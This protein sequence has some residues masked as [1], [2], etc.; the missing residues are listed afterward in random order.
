MS[1][2]LYKFF[3][4]AVALSMV[5]ALP[6]MALPLPTATVERHEAP[7][8]VA[9]ETQPTAPAV[10][11]DEVPDQVE[12][13]QEL[14]DRTGPAKIVIELVDQ[15]AVAIY[16]EAQAAKQSDVAALAATR[17]QLAKIDAAQEALQPV[18]DK[19][20]ATV[21]YRT[22][23]V[24]NGIYAIVEAEK[25]DELAKQPGVKA[26]H[27][28]ITKSLDNWHSVPLIGAPQLWDAGGLFGGLDGSGMKI[29]VID[30]GI[31]YMH[32]NFGGP[33]TQGAY[34]AN[35]T[36]VITDTY[37]GNLLYP[38]MKVVGGWDFA[39]DDYDANPN[40]PTYNPI[41]SPDPDPADCGDHG[42]H[43]AG[44]AAGYGVNANGTTYA[45]PYNSSLNFGQFKIGPGVAPKASLYSLRVFGCEGSTD[46]TDQ[47][48]EWTV[49]PNGDG[50]FSD[51]LDVINM[52]L[53]S[54][55]GSIYDSS[56]V[57]S[58]NAALAGVLV[59]MSSGNSGDVYYVTG[60]P[61]IA[62]RG[63][64]VAG[65]DDGAAILDG[66]RVITPT[67]LAGVHPASESVLFN[68]AGSGVPVTATLVYPLPG[69]NPAQD[70]RTG[71]Y[72]Y[73]ITNTQMISGNFV[74]QD[75]NEPSCG[76]SIARGANAVAAGAKGV[77]MVDNSGAFDLFISGSAVIPAY[78]APKPVGDALKAALSSGAVDL[79][80][81]HQYKGSV[82]YNEPA[83]QNT[84]YSSSS[85]GPRRG[86][87][88]LKPDIA[89]PAVSVFST[90]NAWPWS[91]GKGDGTTGVSYNGTSMAAPHVAGS[92]A[93]LKQLHPSWSVEE[94]K[95]LA[96]NT[97]TTDVTQ[98]NGAAPYYTP[99]R[100]GAGRITLPKAAASQVIAFNAAEPYLTSVSFGAVEVKGT[101]SVTKQIKVLNKS[102]KAQA[103][104]VSYSGYADVPGVSY[105]VTP[106]QIV[107]PPYG[108]TLVNVTMEANAAQMK[109]TVDPTV[110]TPAGRSWMSEES[111][112]VVL[113][114]GYPYKVYLP[115]IMGGTGSGGGSSTPAPTVLRV[116]VHAAPRPASSMDATVSAISFAAVTGTATIPLAGTP[117]STGLSYPTDI[118]SL[119]S[120]FELAESSPNDAGYPGTDNADL[121]YVGVSN[122]NRVATGGFVTNT[123][124]YFGISTWGDH[125][126]ARGTDAEFDIYIDSD[127]NGTWDY[128]VYNTQA[129][130]DIF[131]TAVVN[132][133]T[134][135]AVADRYINVTP[136]LDTYPFNNNVMIM[137][138]SASR[139]GLNNANPRFDYQIVAF[140]RE[141]P[142][143]DPVD[144]TAKLTYSAAKAGLDFT[145]GSATGPVWFDLPGTN[146]NVNFDQAAYIANGSL[147]ALLLHHHNA[148]GMREEVVSVVQPVKIT[149]MHTND[150]HGNLEPAGSNPGMARLAYKIKQVRDEV[151]AA[152]TLLLD[153]G[154]IMQSTLLSNLKKGEPTIDLYNFV[155]Y[156][157]AT[158]GNH[159]FDWGQQTLISRTKEANFPFV[160]SNLVVNDT[161]NC[162]TAGWTV[163][164]SFTVKPWITKTVG[165]PGN[166]AIIGILGTASI[167]TPYIT[168]AEATQGL[169]FKDPKLAI[170]HYYNDVK[171]AGADVI[172]V[173]SHN[174]NTDG[175]YGYGFT[176][177]G[178]QTLARK[179]V[180]QGT[181]VN[182]IIGGHS[183]T[184]LTA[185]QVVSGTTVVQ[186]H[187]AGRKLGRLDLTVNTVNDT[188]SVKWT[189]IVVG[190]SDPEDAPTKMRVN[191]WAN[192][193][194]YQ[195]QINQVIGYS[196]V[197]LVRNYDG[198]NL[199]GALVNDAIYNDLNNDAE[200]LNDVDMV[201]NNPGG[202]RADLTSATKPFTLT[203]GMLYSVLPFGNAT[204]VGDMTGAQIQD[205][206]NQS[207]T[208]FKG[209]LQ[210]SGIRYSFY[211]YTDTLPVAQ[212]WA[213]GA[214]SITVK[215]RNTLLWEPLVM[216]KTYRIATNEFL[217][218]AGQ[219]GF[220]QFKY[221]KNYSYWGDMLNQVNH[222]ISTTHGTPATAYNGPNNNG[223]KDGRIYRNGTNTYN[224][225]DP[226][227]VVPVNVLHHN[228]AH[229]RLLP[230]DTA[231]GYTNLATLIKQ[232]WAHNPNRTIL[233]NAGDTIQGDAMAAYY[234]AAFTGF[235]PDGTALPITL[236]VNPILKSMNALTY[237]AMTLGN[238]EF[239]YGNYIFTGTLGQANFPLLQANLYD[240]GSYGLAQVNVRDHVTVS[241]PGPAGNIDVAILGIGNHRIPIYELP[242]NIPGLLFTNPVSE[243]Q[244]RAPALQATNDAVIAL[245]HIGFTD[246]PNSVEVD[247]NVDT[248]LAANSTGVDAIIGGHSHTNPSTG[249]GPYKFLPTFVGAPDNT[250]VI[251]NQAYRYNTYLGEIVLGFLP[252][253]SGGYNVVSRAGRYIAN[254][255]NVAQD[256]EVKAIIDPYDAF[257]QTYKNRELGRTAVPIDTTYAYI[258]ETNAANLQVD[259]SLW[260][261]NQVFGAGAVQAHLSGAMTQPSP[262][263]VVMFPTASASNPLTMTV[264]DMFTLMPYE[265][266]L[267]VFTL[268]GP[269]LKTI[270]ERAYRN[271]WYYKYVP[272]WGG[273]SH[274]TT[275]MLDVSAGSIITYDEDPLTYTVGSEYVVGMSINGQPVNFLDA[276]TYYTVS[277][278]N[279]VA[280]GSCNFN[281]GGVTLWPLGQI[282]HDTQY[283]VR[284]VMI[285]YIPTLP[286]P[287]APPAYEGR[288][289]ILP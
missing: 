130:N 98:A 81:T 188:A 211:S 158:Y 243:T 167:E 35:D 124:L 204:I 270:L 143:G 165:A 123:V 2:K 208:L 154:D 160:V 185:A 281:N 246:D 34:E 221:I 15:P 66:F 226:T 8:P 9:Q 162:A 223:L 195:A 37:N 85:R 202:L 175:G 192:D 88:L 289:R 287:I 286:Q 106:Q 10:V 157:V 30:T 271:Y 92:M 268:N 47:A 179:L 121:K 209:A 60:S 12:L 200:P 56:A 170:A 232:E 215:N 169:C 275:C 214:Y 52:S 82:P 112:Y 180:E 133:S 229:G 199:M 247:N 138:V 71:C 213:W 235:A 274:Y 238:H 72:A 144:A 224:P 231:P 241:L 189:R 108:Q 31:D 86:D 17:A 212:P 129:G 59:V 65:T 78:S 134:G 254:T 148:A 191:M 62:A 100:I 27:P 276:T 264:A 25:L 245:T 280:A 149:L 166:Q 114:P 90:Q 266:S 205:L 257:F 3:A 127:R 109:H 260:K 102:N 181:P 196:N 285:D 33:A 269:Q 184:D 116:P 96:M 150:F 24:Y 7:V 255:T 36:T 164:I 147:G 173:L 218:P 230:S 77:I 279:Y 21:L 278:V 216:T 171:A 244:L 53:G 234:K 273:Y 198:D 67:S 105:S 44:T 46:L 137:P 141:E 146:L 282:V 256:P 63:I 95:S 107:L 201:F 176:V 242:S 126:T 155:G 125:N 64:S 142:L 225:S 103:F 50:D 75:W 113:T 110:A 265:N 22:Q 89:A 240:D 186:A 58:D 159:E 61:G 219:D 20:D 54:S 13:P 97:A 111:G 249:F 283:Y 45:G 237:T 250:P 1:R 288:I 139:L 252:D 69:A 104:V 220:V 217:A 55:Y 206:L 228:D 253:G 128:V 194:A 57:A 272:N 251:I 259:A 197:D 236:T 40:N 136:S 80:M 174:G 73:D 4:V 203:Y 79:V 6:T 172:L 182:I 76:G 145:N 23:R 51:H 140:S 239:N 87:S 277:T 233:L 43:V 101:A 161:G 42:S 222:W 41:P 119:V 84:V 117:I 168:I 39:G 156:E 70:Q 190:T 284:D 187:Y 267:V 18:L 210:V 122:N 263:N 183:H 163:P 177:E 93:L 83:Y 135:A 193:P 207:A 14:Q 38:T 248:Y 258:S 115:V 19:L 227:Q 5:I 28:L 11:L 32:A 178:D 261:L 16:A 68:W 132:L 262:P 120:A 99:G 118:V 29:G 74:L 91:D 49:D 153:A 131:V 26:I 94:L 48:I 151:G 152:N